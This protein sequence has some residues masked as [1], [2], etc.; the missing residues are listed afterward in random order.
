MAAALFLPDYFAYRL[1]GV[2]GW[3]RTIAS[4][5]GLLTPGGGDF[6]DEI[7]SRLGIPRGWF[8][9]LSADRTVVGPCTVPGLETLTVVRGPIEASTFGSLLAQLETIGALAEED[10]ASVIAAST[11]THVHVPTRS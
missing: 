6:N 3:S 1:T 9:E 5:S 10:R 4:T 8:G 2:V 11:A 7:F